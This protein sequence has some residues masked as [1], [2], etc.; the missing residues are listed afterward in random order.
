MPGKLRDVFIHVQGADFR[1][2]HKLP[3][4][5]NESFMARGWVWVGLSRGRTNQKAE[6]L[7]IALVLSLKRNFP[8]CP[9]PGKQHWRFFKHFESCC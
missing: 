5:T 6:V 4:C 9:T 3:G 7:G 8:P 2:Q 1:T